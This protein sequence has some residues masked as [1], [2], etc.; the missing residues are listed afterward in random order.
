[1]YVTK[2]MKSKVF[3]KKAKGY[4]KANDLDFEIDSR[5]GKGSHS[6]IRVGRKKTIVKKGEIGRGLLTAILKQLNFDREDF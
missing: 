3:I 5:Q 2:A 4:A 1:M 6:L